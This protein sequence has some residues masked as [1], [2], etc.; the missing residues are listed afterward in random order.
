MCFPGVIAGGAP[1]AFTLYNY[2]TD[3]FTGDDPPW[4]L[5]QLGPTQIYRQEIRFPTE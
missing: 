1:G 5:G 2:S 4:L 3:P